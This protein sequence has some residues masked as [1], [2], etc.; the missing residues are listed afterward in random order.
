[1]EIT[2]LQFKSADDLQQLDK[3]NSAYPIVAD[4]VQRLI[5]NY[6]AEGFKYDPD[7]DGWI[8]LVEPHDVDRVLTEIWDDWCLLDIPWEGIN[9]E[10]DFFQA[11]FLANNEFGLVF[12]IP[13]RPWINGA[14]RQ[15]IEDNL[16]PP[17]QQT[18]GVL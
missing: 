7:G 15:V 16:D 11:V 13:D 3:T 4:L 9:R 5:V 12:V 17:L 8:C 6:E 1:M 14:L 10:G 2:M 18:E